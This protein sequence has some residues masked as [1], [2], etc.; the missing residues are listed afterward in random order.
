MNRKTMEKTDLRRRPCRPNAARTIRVWAILFL[1]GLAP[2]LTAQ[3]LVDNS[4]YRRAKELE[5]M[6]DRAL[7]A[8]EYDQSLQYAEE[9]RVYAARAEVYAAQLLLMYKAN[10]WRQYA[11]DKVADAQAQ[12]AE[13][14]F[15]EGFSLASTE[16]QLAESAYNG[17]A[18]EES[19]GHSRRAVAALEGFQPAA[20]TLP[21]VE[22]AAVEPAAAEPQPVF[23]RFYRVRL[24]PKDRDCL[25]KIAG[26]PFVYNDRYKWEILYEANRDR[27]RYPNN[28][29]LIYPDQML[30][31]PSITGETREGIYDP[32][33][34]YPVFPGR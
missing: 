3:S 2:A 29:H 11:R 18:Y 27:L 13:R 9:A 33:S 12:G 10:G 14:I 26:Y 5:R 25:N 7:K 6:A 28:P 20:V 19:I 1:V 22:P 32:G 24:I 21:A 8:G 15:P 4:D 16:Y 34:E 17:G 31:I 23:P 30:V